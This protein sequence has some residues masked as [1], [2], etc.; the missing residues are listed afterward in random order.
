MSQFGR[1]GELT[2]V[3]HVAINLGTKRGVDIDFEHEFGAT[4]Q[5]NAKVDARRWL[6][7]G[8]PGCGYK[9]GQQHDHRPDNEPNDNG[10][11]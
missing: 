5:G 9:G 7:K 11:A 10:D 2:Q 6:K 8:E 3:V 1:D 4:L